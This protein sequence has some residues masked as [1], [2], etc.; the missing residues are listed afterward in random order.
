MKQSPELP[1]LPAPT[2]YQQRFIDTII[3]T[4]KL[5]PA[6]ANWSIKHFAQLDPFQLGDL[7]RLVTE[8]MQLRK[9]VKG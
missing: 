5:D 2:G 7:K 8:E 1:P 9:L 6:Y 3:A 4:G